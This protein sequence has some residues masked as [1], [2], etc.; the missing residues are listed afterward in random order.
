MEKLEQREP[1]N[2]VGAQE[3]YAADSDVCLA[4]IEYLFDDGVLL[5]EQPECLSSL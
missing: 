5:L 2:R 3:R 4:H 1:V